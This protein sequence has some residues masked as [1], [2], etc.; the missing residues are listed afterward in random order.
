MRAITRISKRS[1]KISKRSRNISKRT[2][3]ISKRTR[4]ISKNTLKRRK[5]KR[6]NLKRRKHATNVRGGA[7]LCAVAAA[8][9]ELIFNDYTI[10]SS[11]TNVLKLRI[12]EPSNIACP[13]ERG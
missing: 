12:S 4:N 7:E 1:R 8:Q 11:L 3:N 10:F 13:T 2:R 9:I 5:L 6:N